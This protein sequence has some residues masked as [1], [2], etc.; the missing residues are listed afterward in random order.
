VSQGNFAERFNM[1]QSLSKTSHFLPI[2]VTTFRC[3]FDGT[4]P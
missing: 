2:F 3:G 4:A 1:S